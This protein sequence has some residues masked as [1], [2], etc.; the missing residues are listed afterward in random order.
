MRVLGLSGSLRER[1]FNTAL[2]RVADAA[3][4]EG[5]TIDVRTLEGIPLYDEDVRQTGEPPAVGALK[6]AV[7][8]A[9]ALLIATPEYNFGIPG[10]LKN[11]IDWVSRPPDESPFVDKPVAVMGAGGVLGTVRAQDEL[12]LI[13]STMGAL[14]LGRPALRVERASTK[15]D[16]EGRLTDGEARERLGHFL[17]ALR[18]WT[19]R[20]GGARASS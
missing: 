8:G 17:A 12:K 16:A 1:S 3:A 13:L 11:A 19:L 5:M 4:P 10:V 9:D 15:F 14:V 7:R 20:V 6:D 18:E 2:L